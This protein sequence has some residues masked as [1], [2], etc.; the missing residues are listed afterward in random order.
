MVAIITPWNSPRDIDELEA[1]DPRWRAGCAAVV[2]PSEYT[3]ASML[4]FAALL[5]ASRTAHTAS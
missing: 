1:G 5:P 2:K 3:S 4:E